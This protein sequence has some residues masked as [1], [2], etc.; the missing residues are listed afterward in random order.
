M[1]PPG[2]PIRSG[3]SITVQLPKTEESLLSPT[4]AKTAT[5]KLYDTQVDQITDPKNIEIPIEKMSISEVLRSKSTKRS[6][7][8][9]DA[10][11]TTTN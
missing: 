2:A 3:Q 5:L 11:M 7:F 8:T 4:D 10:M 1:Q 9:G 6:G